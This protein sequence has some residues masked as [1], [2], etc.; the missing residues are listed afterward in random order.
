MRAQSNVTL[1]Q[2]RENVCDQVA[3]GFLLHLIGQIGGASFLNQSQGVV[4]KPAQDNYES[5]LVF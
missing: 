4:R 5:L 3:I 1:H 2:A